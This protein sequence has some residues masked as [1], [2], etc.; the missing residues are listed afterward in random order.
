MLGDRSSERG[1]SVIDVLLSISY[2]SAELYRVV[3]TY[4]DSTDAEIIS[5]RLRPSRTKKLT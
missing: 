1:L 3:W 4:T 2:S 5:L